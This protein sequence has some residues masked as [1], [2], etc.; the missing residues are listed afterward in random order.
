MQ[1]NTEIIL[2]G[3]LGVSQWCSVCVCVCGRKGQEG[4]KRLL[5]DSTKKKRKQ[6]NEPSWRGSDASP[7]FE[8]V[9]TVVFSFFFFCEP[10]ATFSQPLSCSLIHGAGGYKPEQRDQQEAPPAEARFDRTIPHTCCRVSPRPGLKVRSRGS[11]VF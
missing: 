5:N 2:L 3:S 9:C 11:A 8:R 7:V 6:K 4:E 10:S 1:K